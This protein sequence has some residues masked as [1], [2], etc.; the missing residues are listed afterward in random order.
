[1]P[2]RVQSLRDAC[3]N[4]AN[5][6]S[7]PDGFVQMLALADAIGVRIEAR[8]LL[9]EATLAS[10]TQGANDEPSW[11]VLIDSDR[12]A[13]TSEMINQESRNAPLPARLRTTIAHELLHSMSF[14]KGTNGF[15]LDIPRRKGE[16]KPDHL[17]RVERE[18]EKLS[19]LLLIPDQAIRKLA[20]KATLTL[21][22]FLEL[23]K[24]C[25]VSREVLINRFSLLERDDS[26]LHR[27]GL[28]NIAIGMLARQDDKT[29]HLTPWP[30]FSNFEKNRLPWFIS[31][32]AKRQP[33][34]ASR[35]V[36]DP[37]FVLNG[38]DELEIELSGHHDREVLDYMKMQ[39]RFSIETVNPSK[40]RSCLF[41]VRKSS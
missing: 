28:E 29:F 30:L 26:I 27:T 33:I 38:G 19:P 36:R 25:A 6:T 21:A 8:P 41:F 2:S 39:V 17:L 18:T 32:L 24:R 37:G 31:A 20:A 16:S 4:I 34:E 1:M 23:R 11:T 12:F 5:K 10:S 7:G 3:L 22:D 40:V 35:V 13:A 14:R 15:E 9:V